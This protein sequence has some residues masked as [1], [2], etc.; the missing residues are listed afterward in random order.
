MGEMHTLDGEFTHLLLLVLVIGAEI[1]G[2]HLCILAQGFSWVFYVSNC[3]CNCP[4]FLRY[5]FQGF[6]GDFL[7][8]SYF[9]RY[10]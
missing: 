6:K 2:E 7:Y 3:G 5:S 10:T 4:L 1:H 9:V 8:P